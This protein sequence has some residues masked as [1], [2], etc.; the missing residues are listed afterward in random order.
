MQG[1]CA[2]GAFAKQLPYKQAGHKRGIGLCF[3]CCFEVWQLVTW[4]QRNRIGLGRALAL[5]LCGC[6]LSSCILPH[7]ICFHGF[8][9]LAFFVSARPQPSPGWGRVDRRLLRCCVALSSLVCRP[10]TA[11]I[12]SYTGGSRNGWTTSHTLV[13]KTHTPA[14]VHQ[15]TPFTPLTHTHAPRPVLCQAAASRKSAHWLVG[16]AMVQA[17]TPT[18]APP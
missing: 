15:H 1:G 18:T 9:S 12:S 10:T 5:S 11:S 4:R 13:H 7:W 8:D 6:I 3:L 17:S 16:C 14:M 2:S